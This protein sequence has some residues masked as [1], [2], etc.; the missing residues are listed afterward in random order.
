[1]LTARPDRSRRV[2]ATGLVSEGVEQ[3]CLNMTIQ[4]QYYQLIGEVAGLRPGA[5]ATVT[6][7]ADPTVMTTCQSGI[8]FVVLSATAQ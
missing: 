2:T 4:G 8:P 5:K 6:G 3:G 7:Y 1:M